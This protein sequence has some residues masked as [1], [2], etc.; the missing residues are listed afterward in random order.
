MDRAEARIRDGRVR[1]RMSQ[2]ELATASGLVRSTVQRAE[3]GQPVSGESARALCAVLGLDASA[4]DWDPAGGG[5]AG[6]GVRGEDAPGVVGGQDAATPAAG[7]AIPSR[8]DPEAH[9]GRPGNHVR[10]W[11]HALR[12]AWRRDVSPTPAHAALA[13][14]MLVSVGSA[15]RSHAAATGPEG[16]MALALDHPPVPDAR[17]A[18]WASAA[19]PRIGDYTFVNAGR[20]SDDVRHLFT[21]TGLRGYERAL[22]QS[23]NVALVSDRQLVLSMEPTGPARVSF[24]RQERRHLRSWSV[25]VPVRIGIEGSN[26]SDRMDA[27]VDLHVVQAG[28]D[29]LRIERMVVDDAH[30]P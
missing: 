25:T 20:H 10:G 27:R 11:M 28:P 16:D 7:C 19:V 30:A 8:S 21:D 13:V 2:S 23:E 17:V 29:G 9:P 6:S 12:R 1:R 22:E 14:L 18:E 24:D 4:L 3:A 26:T 5:P 15:I